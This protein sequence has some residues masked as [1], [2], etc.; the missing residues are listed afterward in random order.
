M[1]ADRGLKLLP[2]LLPDIGG[3]LCHNLVL[4]KLSSTFGFFYVVLKVPY[5]RKWGIC[6][7]IKHEIFFKKKAEPMQKLRPIREE[8]AV[9]Y[10]GLKQTGTNTE[11]ECQ[12]VFWRRMNRGTAEMDSM[13]WSMNTIIRIIWPSKWIRFTTL[14]N[15]AQISQ[16]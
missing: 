10:I 16:L 8:W 4:R 7:I 5:W 14:Q 2:A 1:C 9:R 12:R 13:R 6:F 3:P 15:W 11:W